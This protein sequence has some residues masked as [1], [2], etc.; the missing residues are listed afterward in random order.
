[1]EYILFFVKIVISVFYVFCFVEIEL[2]I[3]FYIECMV[4]FYL[5]VYWSFEILKVCFFD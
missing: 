4:L 3:F 5:F 2:L 1:M